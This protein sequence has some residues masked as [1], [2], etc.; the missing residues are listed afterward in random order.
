ME[1]LSIICFL[2]SWRLVA[3]KELLVLCAWCYISTSV[4]LVAAIRNV[5]NEKAKYSILLIFYLPKN[6][7]YSYIYQ[8]RNVSA[9]KTNGS[10]PYVLRVLLECRLAFNASILL[11]LIQLPND[12]E[13]YPGLG[14]AQRAN[15]L[16]ICQCNVQRLRGKLEEMRSLLS[17]PGKEH[18]RLDILI[19]YGT[20]CTQKVPNSSIRSYNTDGYQ[21]HRKDRMGTLGGGILV[22][23]QLLDEVC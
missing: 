3:V 20:F 16:R 21:L 2:E 14:L 7:E 4:S 12:V 8:T 1:A 11:L 18:D 19:L 23:K 15:G 17:R 5:N 6:S 9:A 13:V 10:V 22:Y